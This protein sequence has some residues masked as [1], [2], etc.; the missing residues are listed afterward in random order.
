MK[1]R[2]NK[3]PRSAAG[4]SEGA[5]P[6]WPSTSLV[7]GSVLRVCAPSCLPSSSVVLVFLGVVSDWGRCG[8]A[9]G[10]AVVL[11]SEEQG[12]SRPKPWEVSDELWELIEPLIPQPHRPY[13]HPG[14]KRIDDRKTLQGILFV[15]YTGIQWDF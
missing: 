6:H 8:K 9:C 3:V 13:G 11:T 2:A 4:R 5:T 14:R 1:V 10:E 7:D 12:M 15:L